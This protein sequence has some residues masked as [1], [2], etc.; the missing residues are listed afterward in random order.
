[1][2]ATSTVNGLMDAEFIWCIGNRYTCINI[3]HCCILKDFAQGVLPN[4][5]DA[6][7]IMMMRCGINSTG[8]GFI[9]AYCA[10]DCGIYMV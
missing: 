10:K 4:N 7:R 6:C 9:P 2:A 5:D 3:G 1:M 8:L